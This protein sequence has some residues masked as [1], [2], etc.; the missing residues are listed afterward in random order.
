EEGGRVTGARLASEEGGEQVVHAR[1]VI[2]AD[3]SSST[4]RAA[5]GIELPSRPYHHAF[6][7]VDAE[8]PAGYQDAMRI[9]LHPAGGTLGVPEGEDRVGLGVLV[10]RR[11][12]PLF[13]AGSLEDKVAAIGRRSPLLARMKPMPRGAHLY[14]LS[15]GHASRYVA[16]GA[17]LLGD[18]VHV[19]NPTV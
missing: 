5:L 2:G 17:A 8:R 6:Y 14:A 19:T 1:L 15:R 11:D 10:H 16:R 13:R 9:E 7:I 3:G 12:E 4:V 18:A